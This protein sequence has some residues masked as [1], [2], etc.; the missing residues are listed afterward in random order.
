MPSSPDLILVNGLVRT[1]D[2]RGT[3]QAVAVAGG[4]V[5]AV[6]STAEIAALRVPQTEVVDLAGR[7][8]LPG[9]H[10]GHIHLADWSLRRAP[11]SVDLSEAASLADVRA[12]VRAAAAR[13]GAGGWI[14]GHGWYEG[15]IAELAG[16]PPTRHDLDEVSPDHPVVLGHF[17]EHGVWANTAALR[18]CGIGEDGTGMLLETDADLVLSRMPEPTPAERDA[19]LREAA[20]QLN[21]LGVT[22]VT[23]PMV[24]PELTGLY[25][26]ARN[27][28]S[29][30]VRVNMLLHWTGLARPNSVEELERALTYCG[31]SSG[32]G[33]EW[34]RVAGC[35]LFAD[36]VPALLTA[37]T[38]R[39]YADGCLGGL[40]VD[41]DSDEE[42]YDELITM[43][44]MLH[45]RRFQV[46]VHAT[47]DRA[48]DAAMD[49]FAAAQR[50]D[51]WPRARHAIIHANLLSKATAERMA[52]HG[53]PVNINSLI[54][55]TVADKL[56]GLYGDER[57]GYT[58]P[59][60]TLIDAGVHLADTSDAPV[61]EPD[62]RRAVEFLVLREARGSGRVS[63]P[64]QRIGREEA[65]RA[66]TAEAAYQEGTDHLKGTVTPG[67]LA[68]FAVLGA[69]PMAVDAHELHAL[70]VEMTFA[71]GELIHG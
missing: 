8:L 45:G 16:R 20:G 11:Y 1:M 59:A 64:D 3:A 9:I 39:P 27:A 37:W 69:D 53:F 51:P 65:L 70:P 62:W 13:T 57:A 52:E 66:W 36:G 28:G 30:S 33:D 25:L 56:E 31:V 5:T 15:R 49:G 35:K 63:G 21:R 40:V 46:Q 18:R 47:G 42:R 10:D 7:T 22:S 61:V 23:D 50:D 19:A 6:G 4:R 29:L 17:S 54:K 41:G 55:W 24:S 32:L 43:I 34:L 12:A 14:R 60:R 58:M 67:K 26:R 44:R 68:D 38:W 2:E 48:C 71:G